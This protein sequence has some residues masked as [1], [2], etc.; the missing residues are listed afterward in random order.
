[1]R[2]AATVAFALLF[3][4]PALAA[5]RE[6]TCEVRVMGGVQMAFTGQGGTQSATSDHWV[7]PEE[8]SQLLAK[9]ASKSKKTPNK[10][11]A[12]LEKQAARGGGLVGPLS[13]HCISASD[14][15]LGS[16][17]ILPGTNT[18]ESVPFKPGTYSLVTFEEKRGQLPVALRLKGINY[19]LTEPGVLVLTRFDSTGVAGTFTFNARTHDSANKPGVTVRNIR[20]AG[21]FDIPCGMKTRVCR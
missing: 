21:S 18:K 4:L 16:L 19:M 14:G 11:Q 10:T 8:M 7:S 3:C 17:S 15:A 13:L 9:V 1:M 6:G 5:K 12:D 2:H 20:V